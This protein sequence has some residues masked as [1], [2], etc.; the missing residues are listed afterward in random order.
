[1]EV[2]LW[3]RKREESGQMGEAGS[4]LQISGGQWSGRGPGNQLDC[5]SIYIRPCWRTT[6]FRFSFGS[7]TTLCCPGKVDWSLPEDKRPINRS[8]SKDRDEQKAHLK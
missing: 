5:V 8:P 4:P 1:M 2:D 6:P 7:Q 3:V